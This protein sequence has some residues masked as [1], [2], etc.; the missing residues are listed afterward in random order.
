MSSIYKALAGKTSDKT[1]KNNEKQFMNKQRTLLISSRGVNFR[2]RHLI[3]DLNSLLPHSRKEPKLDTK[4]DLGQL[5]EIAELYNCNN[6]LFFEARK[7]QDLYLWLSKPPNGPTIKFY[8]QNLHTMDELNFT[9]NCLKGSRPVLSFDH[10]F[11]TSPQYKL[12]KELLIQ[13]F[14]VPPN[15]RK[16]KPFVDHVMSFSIVDDKIWVRT[17]EI[18]NAARNKTE[19]E[20]EEQEELSLVEIGPRFV[21]TTILILEGS[22]G[23]PKIYENKQY[24]SPNVVRAQQKQQAA[25]EAKSR[26]EAAVE[27]KI[28]RRE[29]VLAADPL[30]NDVVFK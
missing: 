18:S 5:N 2:H 8:V 3:Q 10:R 30:S 16:S 15:A 1:E 11:D 26:S 21:M 7:H 9:G 6:I 12:I 20:E 17:Y 29:N 24:V 25:E 27:R 13:N 4:K 19:Y 22:F 14:G 23:G 28:R